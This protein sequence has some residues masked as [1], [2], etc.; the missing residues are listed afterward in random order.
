MVMTYIS[1]HSVYS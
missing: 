1:V